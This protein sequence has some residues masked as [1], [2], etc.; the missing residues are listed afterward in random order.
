MFFYQAQL[1]TKK[2]EVTAVLPGGR[3]VLT[4]STPTES[5]GA[6]ADRMRQPYGGD[7]D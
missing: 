4:D 7:A 5:A 1:F 2:G 6:G 3:R